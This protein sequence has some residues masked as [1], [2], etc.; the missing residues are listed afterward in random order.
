MHE[1]NADSASDLDLATIDVLLDFMYD[2]LF[3]GIAAASQKGKKMAR[4]FDCV[5]YIYEFKDY[6]CR[7][8]K[9]YSLYRTKVSACH[10]TMATA[11]DAPFIGLGVEGQKPQ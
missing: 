3:R 5:T 4:P 9:R 11:T 1:D 7:R 2:E 8:S 10:L 6:I